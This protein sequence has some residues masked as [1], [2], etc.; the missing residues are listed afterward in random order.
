MKKSYSIATLLLSLSSF[1]FGQTI[2][3]TQSGPRK[4]ILEEFTGVNCYS[5]PAGHS[6]A[7]GLLGAYENEL[8]VIS[9][10]PTNSAFTEPYGNQ[11]EFRRSFLD[12]F[13][14][15]SYCAPA[16]L[17]RDMPSAF[18]NRRIGTDGDRLQMRSNW[19]DYAEPVMN[20][21]HSPMNI[22]IRSTY[23]AQTEV[24]TID[25]EIYYHTDVTEGNS[26]YVFLAEHGLQSFSQS[27]ADVDP[28]IYENNTF[29]ETV[30]VGQWGDPV[31][32]PKTAGSLFSTQLTFAMADAIAPM[33]MANL[34]VLAFV[35]EDGSTEIYTGIQAPAD[36]GLASTG[37]G[38]V[39]VDE[40]EAA[41]L[42]LF[43]NPA[44]D[45]VTLNNV[46]ADARIS[47]LN[48]LGQTVRELPNGST[49]AR[50]SISDLEAGIYLVQCV[51]NQ[52]VTAA[53]LVKH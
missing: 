21:A 51:S 33:V 13:Y 52:Q 24:L 53:R 42:Q 36:G 26:F 45:M 11:S 25:V 1:A 20:D 34:D 29:R 23:N 8:Y 37:T 27:G 28:Y 32:G 35:I 48:A 4:A 2:V 50:F 15:H 12:S 49:K 9:Y 14:V 7:T 44:T 5:C 31:T 39:S 22:G 47:I 43:P 18:I 46:P 6:V 3:N 41:A 16:T 19:G 40:R 38:S 30:T 17:T 10:C